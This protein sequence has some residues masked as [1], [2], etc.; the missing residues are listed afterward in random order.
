[1]NSLRA[2]SQFHRHLIL[3]NGLIP[4]L[5][6]GMDGWQG[7][8]GANPVEFVTRATGILSLLFLLL[9]LAVTPLRHLFH[10]IWL[11][12]QRRLLGLFS[13]FYAI[14]HLLAY[15]G[16][17]RGWQLLSIPADII[18]RPF[19]TVGMISLLFMVPLAITSTHAM[20]KRMGVKQWKILHRLIYIIA[21]GG[22]IHYAL[23]VKS[24]FTYP[25]LFAIVLTFFLG[26][27]LRL[28]S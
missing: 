10:W 12:K 17:D 3:V 16:G 25:F 23:I 27:R 22:V 1:M 28:T 4:I 11:I 13:F 9:T 5:W 21:I 14:L 2:D 26:Y 24:D 15:V 18:R 8:L 6:I 19:I 7:Q 20:I